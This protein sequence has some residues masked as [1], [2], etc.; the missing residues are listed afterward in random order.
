MRDLF[1]YLIGFI[2]GT[3]FSLYV[4]WGDIVW[5]RNLSDKEIND[6]KKIINKGGRDGIN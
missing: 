6:I 5:W 1:F 4:L 3:G 2:C